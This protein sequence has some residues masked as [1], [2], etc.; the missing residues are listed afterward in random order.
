MC[1]IKVMFLKGYPERADLASCSC[2]TY[3]LFGQN[4]FDAFCYL[5]RS[6]VTGRGTVLCVHI[7]HE[8]VLQCEREFSGRFVGG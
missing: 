4:T 1:I 8:L 7:V 3:V 2:R 6:V 5:L